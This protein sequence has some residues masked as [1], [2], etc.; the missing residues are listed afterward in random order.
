CYAGLLNQVF[1][2]LLSNAIDAL[3]FHVKQ[4]PE[5]DFSP[6]IRI[7]T[8]L[9]Y[10]VN[11]GQ[12]C[13]EISIS[14]NGPGIPSNIQASIFDPFFTTKPVGLGTGL[15]LSIS[16]QIVVE[17]HQGKINCC[18]EPG[19]GTEFRIT[20]PAYNISKTKSK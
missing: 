16:Y 17:K 15:G 18:S 6:E 8:A 2:N 1:M 20:I 5:E 12:D 3:E 11:K 9:I 4:H 10:D 14:D 19:E 13:L 7:N